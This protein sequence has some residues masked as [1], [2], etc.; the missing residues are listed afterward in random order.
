MLAA[1]SSAAQDARAEQP[2]PDEAD[3]KYF[4]ECSE[5]AKMQLL[6]FDKAKSCTRAYMSIKLSFVPGVGFDDFDA[7][8]AQE[9]AAVNSF[10]YKRYLEWRLRNAA[11]VNALAAT[12][13]S[14]SVSA[15]D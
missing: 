14:S 1:A 2:E 5:L 8:S 15:E 12:P 7:L 13:R 4:F 10:G 6:S 11:Q 3:L 9:K